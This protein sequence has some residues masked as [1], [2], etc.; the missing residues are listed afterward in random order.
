M[1][2]GF[3]MPLKHTHPMKHNE[4]NPDESMPSTSKEEVINTS[5]TQVTLLSKIT[6]VNKETEDQYHEH[7]AHISK[8]ISSIWGKK[9]KD[10]TS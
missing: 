3:P 6:R 8:S 5:A 4:N 1:E 7:K 10:S 2:S 9:K